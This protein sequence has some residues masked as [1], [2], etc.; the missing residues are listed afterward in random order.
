[1]SIVMGT[2][3]FVSR[4]YVTFSSNYDNTV[5]YFMPMVNQTLSS[6]NNNIPIAKAYRQA[7]DSFVSNL[8]PIYRHITHISPGTFRVYGPPETT[9]RD[10]IEEPKA[11]I[12]PDAT[13]GE[14]YVIEIP[15]GKSSIDFII[16]NIGKVDINYAFDKSNVVEISPISGNI[17]VGQDSKINLKVLNMPVMEIQSQDDIDTTLKPK[18]AKIYF[19]SNAGD[20][21]LLV[22]Y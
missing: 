2:N 10:L 20:R 14:E 8:D 18:S 3:N 21:E 6:I 5:D 17:L 11:V 7:Y 12:Q 1:M 19:K 4:D 16:R 22:K 9:L 13:F 15:K